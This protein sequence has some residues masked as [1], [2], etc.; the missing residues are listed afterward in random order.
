[1]P[2]QQGPSIR[3]TSPPDA[4]QPTATPPGPWQRSMPQQPLPQQPAPPQQPPPPQHHAAPGSAP[5]PSAPAGYVHPHHAGRDAQLIHP[6]AAQ[7]SSVTPY[8]VPVYHAPVSAL[9]PPPSRGL[10]I[11]AMVLGLIS[12]TFGWTLVVLPIIGLVFGILAL[13]REPAGR[14]LAIT[15]IITSIGGMLWV[16]LFYLLP[17]AGVVAAMLFAISTS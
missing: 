3:P 4:P 15:G 11:T 6:A 1:M 8:G 14:P 12:V 7:A 17:L 9:A 2:M 16:L 10:S 5:R 13:R